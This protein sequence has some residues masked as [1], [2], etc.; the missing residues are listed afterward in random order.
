MSDALH[1]IYEDGKNAIKN[2]KKQP[3]IVNPYIKDTDAYEAFDKGMQEQ[4]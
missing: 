2:R 1:M 3:Y 4:L